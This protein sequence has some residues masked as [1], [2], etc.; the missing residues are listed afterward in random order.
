MMK[1]L[2]MRWNSMSADTIVMSLK[3]LGMEVDEFLFPKDTEDTRS[4]R[5]LTERIVMQLMKSTYSF[6]FSF[7]YYP[8][9]SIACQ[10]CSVPYISW[11]YDSPFVQLYS[12]TVLFDTNYIFHFDQAEV[13]KLKEYGVEHIKY[14]PM[15][16]P[17]DQYDKMKLEDLTEHERK[18]YI[19]DVTFV[20]SLY[21]EPKQRLYDRLEKLDQYTLGFINGICDAQKN[22][23]GYNF[24][25]ETIS[26]DLEER[27][28]KVAPLTQNTDGFEEIS[29]V[30]ANYFLARKV[31]AMERQEAMKM[32]SENFYTKIFTYAD[33]GMLSKLNNMGGLEY[34]KCPLAFKGAKININISLKSIQTGIPLRAMDIMGSGGFLLTNFQ[35]DFL[36]HFI[37]DVDFVYYETIAD[38]KDKVQY[39]LEH[40]EERMQIAKNGYQKVKEAF[41]IKHCL[42]TMLQTVFGNLL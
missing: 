31:T 18:K 25:Q 35:S 28:Q 6:V 38:M 20:G 27:L 24:L 42:Q 37:P 4:G 5:E 36:N 14:M 22:V 21:T 7:N 26:K 11:V 40:D 32:L 29:W 34:E 33:T 9:I 12:K 19:S 23:Y 16:V 2:Y 39:Y 10:T 13:E 30:Y 41:T 15:G 3:S 1:V 8:V 17:V